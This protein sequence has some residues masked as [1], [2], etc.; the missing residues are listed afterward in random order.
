MR[1]LNFDFKEIKQ[2]SKEIEAKFDLTVETNALLCPNPNEFYSRA[3]L[4]D[5]VT[6][7]FRLLPGIKYK[8]KLAN[9]SFDR[10]IYAS[11]CSWNDAKEAAG[12][13]DAIDIDVCGVSALAEICQFDAEQAFFSTIMRPGANT[14]EIAPQ[15]FLT[16]YWT[17]L[18]NLIQEEV[19]QIRWQGDTS[20][21]AATTFLAECD[22]YE[23]KLLAGVGVANAGPVNGIAGSVIT[24]ANVIAEISKVYNG[25]PNTL[26]HKTG[27]LR[28]YVSANVASAYLEAVAENNTILY[29]TMNPELTYLGRIKMVVQEGM[30]DDTMLLTRYQNLIY[31][32]DALGDRESLKAV[33]L[34]DTVAEPTLRTRVNMKLAFYLSNETE[35]VYYSTDI[36]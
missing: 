34:T 28:L 12:S 9:Q 31:A 11:D 10:A 32:F 25:L 33:N 8:T 2:A 1:E 35:M 19:A 3:Y 20:L 17:Q 29:T 7:N 21:N 36:A 26:K 16:E 24:K 27:D 23:K 6:G 4:T 14:D 30:S 22:G 15:M 5:D 13:L 18:A